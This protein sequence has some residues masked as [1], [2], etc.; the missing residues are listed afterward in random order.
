[1]H[2]L[3]NDIQNELKKLPQRVL[4][5]QII[6]DVIIKICYLRPYKSSEIAGILGR[7]DKYILRTF[8]S[9]MEKKGVLEYVFP[10]M[11]N[12]PDQ[13]YKTKIQ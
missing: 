6:E 2:Q 7:T 9:P 5:P 12:H 3:P 11:P 10:D 4:N 13:A 8:I 1:V